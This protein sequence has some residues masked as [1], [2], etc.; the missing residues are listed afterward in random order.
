MGLNNLDATKL[1]YFK[2]NNEIN[3][4]VDDKI[5]LNKDKEAVKAFFAENVEPNTKNFASFK[6]RLNYLVKNDYIE[7]NVLDEYSYDFIEELYQNLLDQHF[8][9]Q[10]FM[11]AY[12]FY[13]QYALKTND[14]DF[15][16]ENY[17]MRILFNALL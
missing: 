12:K 17:E 9:F 7:K 15:Y 5:P 6:E 13:N 11:A 1:S 14:G 8:Q 3:I 16:L 2:L 4:P 10:S